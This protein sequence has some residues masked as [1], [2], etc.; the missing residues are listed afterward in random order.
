MDKKPSA[1]STPR[2]T[3]TQAAAGKQRALQ[4]EQ[5]R[6][7]PAEGGEEGGK[8]K[9]VQTSARTQPDKVP[10]Q[11]LEKPGQEADMQLKPRFDAPDYK[12]S[13]KLE[14]MTALITGGDSGIGRAVAVLYAREGADVAIVYL[15]S[16]ED[17]EET[18]RCVEKEGRKCLLIP[19]DVKDAK[20]C[21]QAVERTVQELNGLH[22]LVNNAAFQLHAHSLQDITDERL[23]ETFKTNIYGYFYMARAAEPHLKKG[24]CIIN[25]GSVVGLKGSKQLLDYSATKGAIHAFTMSLAS[26]LLEKGIRVNA[27]A[28]GPVWTPLNPADRSAQ[29]IVEFGKQTDYKRPAQPEELSPAYVFLASPVCSSYITGIVL[30][31]TGSVGG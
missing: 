9:G 31:V 1:K 20:F 11:H 17:A 19:G 14:G 2:S 27:V 26:S 8:D 5:D 25:T 10:A 24:S 13:G 28:P 3:D 12:G 18:K 4:R 22:I 23:D 16:H 21:K 6:K 15:S 7:E 29:E 30:P